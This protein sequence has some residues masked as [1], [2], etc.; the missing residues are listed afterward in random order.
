[1]ETTGKEAAPRRAG[2][3]D[4][5]TGNVVAGVLKWVEPWFS[6]Y[7]VVGILVLGVAP[8]FMPVTV[9]AAGG[10]ATAVGLV[11]AAFYVGGLFAPVL[12]SLTDRRGWQRIVF[13]GCFPVM[14]AGVAAFAFV[15]GTW[16]WALFALIFGGAGSLACSV[17]GLFVVEAHPREEWNQR[18]SWF[19]LAYGAGQVVGLVIA[20]VAV[21]E[22]KT[23]W[24]ITAALLLAGTVL[25]RIKLPALGPAAAEP[26]PAGAGPL[27]GLAGKYGLFLL[28]WLLVMTGV[29]TFFNVVPL[30]MRDAFDVSASTSSWLFLAGAAVGT[31]CY[32]LAGTLAGRW[33]AGQVLLLG[34]AMMTV[35]FGV[36]FGVSHV[37]AG[38]MAYIGGAGLVIAAIAY[39]FVVAAA[40]MMIAGLAPGS[41]GSA[42]GLLNGIIAGGAV[43]G[44]L[45]PSYVAKA[46]GY[47]SLTAMAAGILI[48][49]ALVGI[50]LFRRSLWLGGEHGQAAHS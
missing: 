36:M 25:A 10:D 4:S 50:P 22:L 2:G 19:R 6:A 21:A 24:L 18:L 23:G 43:I 48:L 32:P 38:G 40:T 28:M 42:M 39:T 3:G 35:S 37:H 41:E 9:D 30:V 15:E 5:R 26:R 14:A 33:G 11:V 8:I 45:V 20:A 34:I 27:A 46:L 47:S 16:L 7:G 31:L 13:V 29:Q 49:A 12:S 44:A 1:M 17:A